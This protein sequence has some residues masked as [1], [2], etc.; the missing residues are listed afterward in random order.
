M[1]ATPTTPKAPPIKTQGIKTKLVP[2]IRE[3]ILWDG[4]GRWVEPFMGSGVV[5][6]NLAPKRALL[7]DTNIH[8]INFYNS[9]KNGTITGPSSREYLT[10]EGEK[11]LRSDGEYYYE[12]RSR[13]N[14]HGNPLDFLFLSRSCFN[15]V[16]RFN[17]KGGFN[18]PFCKKPN[19]FRLALITKITNQIEWARK[20]IAL[21]DFEFATK[22][23]EETLSVCQQGDFVYC[24][25]PYAG[26]HTDYFNSWSEEDANLLSERLGDGEFGYAL[27]TW[28]SNQYR[29]NNLLESWSTGCVVRTRAHFYH[30]GSTESLRNEMFEALVIKSGYESNPDEATASTDEGD[31]LGLG[32]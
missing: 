1:L 18:V 17:R 9:I 8:I 31:Q 5:A 2:F 11:L 27:S 19:R 10:Q 23:W 32:L 30:V 26:R 22:T 24:D 21:G 28:S 16:M 29:T 3:N 20:Q 7:C 13:F 6:L 4:Q 14:E 25:P 12:V 15:G